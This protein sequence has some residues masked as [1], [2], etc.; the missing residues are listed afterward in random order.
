MKT[1]LT[2]RS[3]LLALLMVV[4]IFSTP[5]TTLAQQESVEVQAKLAAK[6]DA[7][8]DTNK[9]AWTGMRFVIY[10]SPLLGGLAG[11]G[12]G[13]LLPQSGTDG[14][15]GIS[16]QEIYG[17]CIGATVGCLIPLIVMYN[18]RLSPPPERLLGKWPEYIDLYTNA[19]KTQVRLLRT[20]YA[21]LDPLF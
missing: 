3:L 4:L 6:R 16:D 21:I 8:T 9:L 18:Y 15:L 12:I 11:R 14:L 7:E 1:N 19:Y 5:F 2:F 13:L 20:R 10:F 17:F